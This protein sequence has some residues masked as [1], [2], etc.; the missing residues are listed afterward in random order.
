MCTLTVHRTA[1]E[2]VA[3]MN[4]DETL[5][6]GPEIP[7]TIQ[8]PVDSAR[9]VAP[10]DSDRGG[11]WMGANAHGVI[12]CLLNAYLPGESLLPDP[13][14]SRPS[15]GQIIPALLTHGDGPSALSWLRNSFDPTRYPSFTLIVCAPERTV[16]YEWL[17]QDTPEVTEY[18][19]EWIIRSSSGWDSE[20]VRSWRED[21]FRRW[22]EEGCDSVGPLPGFH[23]LQEQDHLE[24]SP[25]M[26]R[27]WSA[28]R[29]I[30]QA[31]VSLADQRVEMLYW[32]EPTP[33]SDE[34]AVRLSLD[35]ISAA[36]QRIDAK[37]T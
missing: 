5:M 6:R 36:G 33:D 28:T 8:M 1:Q 16:C 19:E 2:I 34:P 4:R 14:K 11:T 17:R 32:A 18:D 3:T 24:R 30:T 20:E 10:C 31:A 27:E 26:R 13:S 35:L 9:W 37:A 12:A 21:R 29:S 23:I 7:P 25:L 15:R 22:R